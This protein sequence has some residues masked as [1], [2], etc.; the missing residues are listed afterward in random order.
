MVIGGT[1]LFVGDAKN[2]ESAGYR[3]SAGT[4][5]GLRRREELLDA[6]VEDL[7][8]NGLVDFS[9][10]RAAEAAGATH[11]VLLYHFADGDELL[12]EAVTRLR[13]RRIAN[14]L[15]ASWALIQGHDTFAARVAEL[16][17]ILL[18]DGTGLR[19]LD[20]AIGLALYDPS[21]YR[22]LGQ[23]ASA[24]YLPALI[25]SCPETWT[26]QRKLEISHL[27]MATMRGFLVHWLTSGD[28]AGVDQ[29]MVALIRLIE[30]EEQR[31]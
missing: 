6:V 27:V 21:R 1:L 22:P 4:K 24:Q 19:V 23:E 20:Q 25:S 13:E 12:L 9:L 14:G 30:I 2:S 3:R 10:R 18:D 8:A 29:G 11:K 5:R 26:E 31:D 16:W 17:L 15:R 28:L 7:A